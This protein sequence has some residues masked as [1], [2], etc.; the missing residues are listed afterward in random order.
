MYQNYYSK[1]QGR[2]KTKSFGLLIFLLIS[3]VATPPVIAEVTHPTPVMPTQANPH[4]LITEAQALY[5][6]GQFKAAIPLWQKAAHGFAQLEDSLNQ[7]MA[8]SNLSLTYQQLEQWESAQNAIASSLE[9]LNSRTENDL[10]IL[11]QTLD[12]QGKLQQETGKLEEALITWQKSA[13]IYQKQHNISALDQNNLN[14]AQALRDLGLYPRACKHLLEAVSLT[15]ISTCQQLNHLTQAELKTKLKPIAANASITTLSTLRNLGDI[16]L[17]IGQPKQ[18]EQILRSN[19]DLAKKLNSLEE[20]G[21]TYLSL[22][23]TYQAL[24]EAEEIQSQRLRYQQQALDAYNKAA[25]LSPAKRI[26]VQAQ[27]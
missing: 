18:S 21:V 26:Q 11:A 22:G 6:Q 2:T 27:L 16:L 7:A 24:A 17:I 25:S 14:Q 4:Q 12:I 9:L 1:G 8:L 3:T 20:L 19:L 5:Q 13:E 15:D 10:I 23:N